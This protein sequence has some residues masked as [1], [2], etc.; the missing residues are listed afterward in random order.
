M[1]RFLEV[2]HHSVAYLQTRGGPNI[3]HFIIPLAVGN[4]LRIVL[5]HD[6]ID[7]LPGRFHQCIFL[8]RDDHITETE[9]DSAH[10]RMF[11]AESLQPVKEFDSLI[12]TR[13]SECFTHNLLKM[14]F[15]Y[16][17][18]HILQSFRNN[19]VKNN[20]AGGRLNELA[21]HPHL[22]NGM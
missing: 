22:Y 12:V 15:S 14:L 1:I 9:R 4:D 6:L 19:S 20:P 8:R 17:P 21:V 10:C 13:Q 18:I 7:L 5:R 11:K 2:S 16:Y 3:D